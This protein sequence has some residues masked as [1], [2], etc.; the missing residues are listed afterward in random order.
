MPKLN[1]AD[2]A[3]LAAIL[4]R[5]GSPYDGER[6]AAGLLA[7]RFVRDR[8]LSWGDVLAPPASAERAAPDPHPEPAPEPWRV[9]AAELLLHRDALNAWER[10]F[11]RQILSFPRLSPKQAEM[12]AR[13]RDKV[14]AAS[15]RAA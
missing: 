11:L 14:R 7:D 13:I 4:A 12:L 1:A 15:T 6:A 8:D 5:L 2:R 3:K 9:E 10:D